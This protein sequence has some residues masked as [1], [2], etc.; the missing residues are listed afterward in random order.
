[1]RKIIAYL[2]PRI[3]DAI[4]IG[5]LLAATSLGGL[6]LNGD[7]DLGRHI[8]IGRYILTSGAVPVRDI[9]SHTMTGQRLVPHEWLAQVAFAGVHALLGLTGIVLLVSVV[10]ATAFTLAYREMLRRDIFHI[11][12][13]LIA[14]LAAYASVL[15]WLAR[16]HIFTFLFTAIWAYQL[17][18]ENSRVWLFP[19]VMLVW[20]N[21]HGAFIAG[22]V[23][24]GAH[25]IGW[26]WEYRQRQA[27]KETGMRLVTI[28]AASFAV[29]LINPAGWHLWGTSLGYFGNQFLVDQTIE[30]QSPNFHNWSTWPFVI[31]LILGIL[32]TGLGSRL[33][34]H[35]SILFAGWAL[36]SLYS[37]R[38]IPLFAI[39]VAPYVGTAVQQLAEHS[40]FLRRVDQRLALVEKDLRGAV[41]PIVLTALLAL[42]LLRQPGTS[43]RFSEARFPVKAVDWLSG[44]PQQ[45][46]M[47]NNFIWGGY[48]LYRL[49]PEQSV[50]IDGQTDFYGEQLAREYTRVASLREG[51]ESV[52]EKYDVAWVIVQSDK[53][54]VQALQKELKWRLV[55]RD[56]TAAI[57]H[58]P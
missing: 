37:A 57:L 47:F 54:L 18:N 51:W 44:H 36:L 27:T 50:F 24:W 53:T 13:L 39:I 31:M 22:F 40:S 23:I 6:L 42:S 32:A 12:A 11:L 16:P 1:M 2:V 19:L 38:N 29:T 17:E 7:G 26:M 28:G 56:E 43:N 10:I 34:P 30:Y 52:L 3:Q 41:W 49:W 8:T 21:T 14:I 5:I 45:G 25:L 35:A 15:H 20:A 55:Y 48:L 46:K 58:K 33:R 4:F 9:F